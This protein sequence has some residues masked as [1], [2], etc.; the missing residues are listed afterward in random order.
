MLLTMN[1]K[2][3]CRRHKLNYRRAWYALATGKVKARVVG[4]TWSLSDAQA[5]ALKVFLEGKPG[6]TS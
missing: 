4:R 6:S 1:L 2:G 3:V 5:A